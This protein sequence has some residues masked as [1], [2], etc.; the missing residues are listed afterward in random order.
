MIIRGEYYGKGLGVSTSS[1]FWL[2]ILLWSRLF[3][4]SGFGPTSFNGL[5]LLDPVQSK[6]GA[7]AFWSGSWTLRSS[8]S[9]D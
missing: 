3:F 5:K 4:L 6:F 7:T 1:R 9:S 8:A 2:R